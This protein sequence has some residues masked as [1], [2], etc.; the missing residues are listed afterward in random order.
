MGGHSSFTE[1]DS[2]RL[3]LS[4]EHEP[5]SNLKKD[6]VLFFAKKKGGGA[7]SKSAKN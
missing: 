2:Y 4:T 5:V 1:P 3:I 7:Y 6:C